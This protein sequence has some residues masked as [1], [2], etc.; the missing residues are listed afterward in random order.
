MKRI[1]IL[2]IVLPGLLAAGCNFFRKPDDTSAPRIVREYY[3]NG[4]IKSEITAI[5]T[6]R[7]GITKNYDKNGRLAGEVMYEN[8]MKHGWATNYYPSGKIHSK[9]MYREGKKDGDEIWYYENGKAYRVSPYVEGKLNG[10]Q[11]MYYENGKLKAEVPYKN[12]NPGTGLKEYTK[13]GK[14]ITNYPG[15]VIKEINHLAMN[16]MYILNLSLSNKSRKVQFYMDRLIE[17]VYLAKNT[18]PMITENGVAE[19]VVSVAPG[20]MAVEKLNFIARYKTPLGNPC[21]IQ[22]KFNLAVKN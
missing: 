2:T 4:R 10:I 18:M 19:Y 6:Q 3:D 1:V 21:I 8:N 5:G 13:D 15:I 20:G 9:L 11:K 12:G 17:D 14:L 7:Q 22:K 16:N